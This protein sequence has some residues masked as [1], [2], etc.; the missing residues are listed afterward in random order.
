M[1]LSFDLPKIAQ[2]AKAY[3]IAAAAVILPTYVLLNAF[4]VLPVAGIGLAAAYV[5]KKETTIKYGKAVLDAVSESFG[6][7][8]RDIKGTAKKLDKNLTEKRAAAVSEEPSTVSSVEKA[9]GAFNT[10]AGAEAQTTP[11]SAKPAAGVAQN[12]P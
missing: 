2:K 5:T 12:T 6:I 3:G 8:G 10:E 9:G 11:A 4:W 1:E 7:V